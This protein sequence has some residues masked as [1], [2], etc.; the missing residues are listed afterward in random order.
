VSP[1]SVYYITQESDKVREVTQFMHLHGAALVG[2]R[3]RRGHAVYS[4]RTAGC[5]TPCA[6]M[7]WVAYTHQ[8]RLTHGELGMSR[9]GSAWNSL[10][11]YHTHPRNWLWASKLYTRKYPRMLCTRKIK[12]KPDLHLALT[13]H[14]AMCG[15][16]PD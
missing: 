5:N 1:Y 10:S 12:Q 14:T 16:N 15:A 2:G 8:A 6:N 3:E 9:V 7:A 13:P 4:Y 11:G